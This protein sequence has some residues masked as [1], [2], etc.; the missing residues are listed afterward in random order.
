[1]GSGQ[2]PFSGKLGGKALKPGSYTAG[3]IARD[4]AGNVSE[5]KAA[6]FTVVID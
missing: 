5:A 1:M 4:A 6:S 3:L 2:V